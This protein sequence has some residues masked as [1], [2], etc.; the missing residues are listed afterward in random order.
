MRIISGKY[1]GRLIRP[2][3]NL[4]VRPTTDFAKTGL[5]NI[6]DNKFD[7]ETCECLDL[8][9]GTGSISLELASRGA[10]HITAIDLDQKCV[11]FLRKTSD[12][13]EINNLI[14]HRS[15]VM[16]F[17]RKTPLHF[18]L[19]FADPP[20]DSKIHIEL[21]QLIFDKNI[22]KPDGVFIMEHASREEFTDLK[23]FSFS[24]KYGNVAFSFF[25][26]LD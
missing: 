17:L 6:L 25:Y 2:P 4:P 13:L 1:K 21:H 22:L 5:F 8:F 19:I 26:N 15:D 16:T 14:A 3:G 24:R 18:N 10:R 7:L 12:E 20:F 23:G 9:S 11:V